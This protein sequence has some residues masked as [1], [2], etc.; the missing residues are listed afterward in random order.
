[1][2]VQYI[3][4]NWLGALSIIILSRYDALEN[5]CIIIIVIIIIII[6]IIALCDYVCGDRLTTKPRKLFWWFKCKEI[7]NCWWT[8]LPQ[9]RTP[10]ASVLKFCP[11]RDTG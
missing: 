11:I 3:F 7:Y 1:M 5:L 10:V 9:I 6:I 8:L 4:S 2:F